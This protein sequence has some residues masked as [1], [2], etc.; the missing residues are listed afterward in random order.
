VTAQF[1]NP[2]LPVRRAAIKG[3][4]SC[5]R[6]HAS[7]SM[8]ARSVRRCYGQNPEIVASSVRMEMSHVRQFSKAARILAAKIAN[9]EAPEPR[10]FKG[11]QEEPLQLCCEAAAGHLLGRLRR[12]LSRSRWAPVGGGVESAPSAGGAMNQR[13]KEQA[14]PCMQ[15]ALRAPARLELSTVGIVY[16]LE[17]KYST[18]R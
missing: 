8:N 4:R 11:E 9:M 3:Q 5:R 10:S 18:S 12:L 13:R 6:M 14:E 15:P 17:S 1:W 7:G 16:H 2:R